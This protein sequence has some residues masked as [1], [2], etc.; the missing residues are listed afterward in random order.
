M[1]RKVK[2]L[3]IGDLV[4]ITEETH[5]DRMPD[6]RTGLIIEVERS[7]YKVW[8]TNGETLKVHEMFLE[9]VE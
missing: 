5:D 3:E 4:K 9:R 1:G 8:M 7:F 2:K 6:N